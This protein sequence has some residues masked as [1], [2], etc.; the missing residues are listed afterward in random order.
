M[1]KSMKNRKNKLNP[2]FLI[3]LAVVLVAVLGGLIMLSSW[4]GKN[5]SPKDPS[6]DQSALMSIETPYATLKYPAQWEK[7]LYH[8]G[9]TENGVYTEAFFCCIGD[10]RVELFR[11]HFGASDMGSLIGYTIS[12]GTPVAFSVEGVDIVADPA[13][14]EETR[15][16]VY[17]MADGI[18]TV[19]EQFLTHDSTGT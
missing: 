9:K 5:E 17:A 6:D 14:S 2:L 19:I 1:D 4:L 13:W 3:T 8:E 18:N 12:D 15:I 7:N 11:V 16:M 10:E